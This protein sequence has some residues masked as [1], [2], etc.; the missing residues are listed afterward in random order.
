MKH[1]KFITLFLILILIFPIS[2]FGLDEEENENVEELEDSNKITV[3]L[4]ACVDGDTAKFK[5]EDNSIIKARFLA[6]DTPE[7]VH[8][9]KD[10]EAYGKDAS[11]LTC[12]ILTDATDIVLE[13]DESS[14][15]VDK[16]GRE[17]VWVF[18][19]GVLVQDSLIAKGYAKVAYLYGDYKYTSVLKSS[20]EIAKT[21][22]IGIWSD[23]VIN[24]T[25]EEADNKE[26][27][28]EKKENSNPIIAFFDN[29]L[30]SIFDI[31]NDIL[32]S[33]LHFLDNVL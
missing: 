3:T 30:A 27:K 21:S 17:L 11:E 10:V 32:D 26:E 2:V 18:A 22:K 14:T 6:I 19:D 20:E 33:I 1:N 28:Q 9:T 8:P 24:N 15:K 23:E 16:Y 13:Y 7:T 25:Q 12:K 31:I 5:L 4:E 29:L